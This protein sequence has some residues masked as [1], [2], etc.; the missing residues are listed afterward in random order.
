MFPQ[1]G[2]NKFLI[3]QKSFHK[4]VCVSP[5][6]WNQVSHKLVSH[7]SSVT[8]FHGDQDLAS[9][10]VSHETLFVCLSNKSIDRSLFRSLP[11]L[12][13]QMLRLEKQS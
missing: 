11:A 2:S 5:L 3:L 9:H 6:P 10:L 1:M 4:C 13:S 8:N 7:P 12:H